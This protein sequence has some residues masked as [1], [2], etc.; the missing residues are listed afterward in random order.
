VPAAVE[1]GR[2]SAGPEEQLLLLLCHTADRRR[3]LNGR[4]G[5]L[6]SRSDFRRVEALV[7]R[8]RLPYPVI[9]RLREELGGEF[10][11]QAQDAFDRERDL[12]SRRGALLEA[13][14]QR[15]QDELAARG[16]AALPIK[17]PTLARAVYGDPGARPVVD[18]DFLV[19]LERLPEAEQAI[20][21]F[22]F[23][24]VEDTL[25]Q[26]GVPV[27]H[28]HLRHDAGGLPGVELH[29]RVHWYETRFSREMLDRSGETAQGNRAPLPYELAS[30]LL[31]YSRDGFVGL[32]L[33]AD[34][35]AWWDRH[36]G[37]VGTPAL[38]EICARHPELRPALESGAAV[39]EEV[40]GI[41][42]RALLDMPDVLP[43]R[44]QLATRLANWQ[45]VGASGQ[46]QANVTLVDLLLSPPG[47][48]RQFARRN[49]L[50]PSRRVEELYDLGAR[51][52]WRRAVLRTVHGPKLLTRY[53]I[54]LLALRRGRRWA[55]NSAR[56]AIGD[57][58]APG[59]RA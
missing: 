59:A 53:A 26:N 28:R 4:I 54:A 18:L 55:P 30:L 32:R 9:G 6:A 41:P 16:V 45:G 29:W 17:G 12:A 43:R 8:H 48:V 3:A 42:A 23:S 39:L 36:S 38:S 49:L 57:G 14:M 11:R 33:A 44:S 50:P 1:R 21:R 5:E 46:I 15:Y 47:R 2:P 24:P 27:L 56:G 37:D 31:F 25:A 13:M 7:V 19:P 58:R 34:I 35:A 40:V 22:G 10:P 52:R 51:A 20:A